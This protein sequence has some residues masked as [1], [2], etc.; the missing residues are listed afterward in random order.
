MRPLGNYAIQIDWEDGFNQVGQPHPWA[1]RRKA[2]EVLAASLASLLCT[3][4]VFSYSTR[5]KTRQDNCKKLLRSCSACY[6]MCPQHFRG[7]TSSRAPTFLSSWLDLTVGL[8]DTTALGSDFF[9]TQLVLKKAFQCPM[10][11]WNA[12]EKSLK[13]HTSCHGKRGAA[14]GGGGGGVAGGLCHLF[15]LLLLLQA[16]CSTTASCRSMHGRD[17]LQLLVY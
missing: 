5:C 9:S 7:L 16:P 2:V 6:T 10:G 17:Q 13:L 14:R 11:Y 4:L 3:G 12:R 1:P 15:E 8:E